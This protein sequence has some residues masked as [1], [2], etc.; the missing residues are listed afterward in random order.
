MLSTDK[1]NT[2][3]ENLMKLVQKTPK[4][5]E[6]D[7]NKVYESLCGEVPFFK[8]LRPSQVFH[9]IQDNL[10]QFKESLSKE[11]LEDLIEIWKLSDELEK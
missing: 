11:T 3:K 6:S 7:V 9:F 8:N 5:K 10:S 2:N 4:L 1:N